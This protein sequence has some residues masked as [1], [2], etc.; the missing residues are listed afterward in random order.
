MTALGRSLQI[1]DP[2]GE[3]PSIAVPAEEV[4]ACIDTLEVAEQHLKA[5]RAYRSQAQDGALAPGSLAATA[6]TTVPPASGAEAAAS[7]GE[8]VS[9][10]PAMERPPTPTMRRPREAIGWFA[11]SNEILQPIYARAWLRAADEWSTAD[12]LADVLGKI[13]PADH[14]AGRASSGLAPGQ[15]AG[16]D[17]PAV[18]DPPGA[19]DQQTAGAQGAPGWYLLLMAI[20]TVV[21]GVIFAATGTAFHRWTP[22]WGI[23][24][25]LVALAAGG[26]LSRTF[27]DMRGAVG[28]LV[29]V[30]VTVFAATW[31][32]PGG[33][34]LVTNQAI[35]YVWLLGS[36]V[37]GSFGALSPR[38]WFRDRA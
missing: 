1:G 27:A 9:P 6:E 33:D 19:A 7:P 36:L 13:M 2:E 24:I 22:P 4:D 26:V 18:P 29:A 11:L 21:M 31:W 10:V 25:A 32:R 34:V 28:Y 8:L 5:I 37:A 15:P 3:L 17:E 14:P 20:F 38:R 16:T 23:V 12:E 30:V 35:G